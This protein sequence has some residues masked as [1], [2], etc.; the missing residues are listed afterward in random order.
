VEPGELTPPPPQAANSSALVATV[1]FK[2]IDIARLVE[3]PTAISHPHRAVC[4]FPAG[5]T[6]IVVEA[7][8][9]R[10]PEVGNSLL[11]ERG[12]L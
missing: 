4:G 3:V 1:E 6:A 8:P 11:D 7:V 5:G 2:K 12:R 9:A 10:E